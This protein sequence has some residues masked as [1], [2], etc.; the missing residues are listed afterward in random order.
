MRDDALHLF[1]SHNRY[2]SRRLVLAESLGNQ[3]LFPLATLQPHHDCSPRLQ[4]LG[5]PLDI[6]SSHRVPSSRL[7][8]MLC[9]IQETTLMVPFMPLHR[10]FLKAR[11]MADFQF[12]ARPQGLLSE[13]GATLNCKRLAFYSTSNHLEMCALILVEI[14]HFGREE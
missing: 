10:L 4:K 7:V 12:K 3:V 13:I 5:V 6:K 1:G 14:I 2:S 11:Q 8:N 9:I